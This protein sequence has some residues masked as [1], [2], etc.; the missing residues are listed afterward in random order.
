MM[1]D[2]SLSQWSS[3]LPYK[4]ASVHAAYVSLIENAQHFIYIENQYFISAENQVAVTLR[5][6]IARAISNK[7]VFRAY[8]CVPITPCGQWESTSIKYV[9]KWQY[10][11]INKDI[12]NP[13]RE[14]FPGVSINDYVS[15]YSF[16]TAARLGNQVVSDQ[17]YIHSKLMIVDDRVAVIGSANINDRSLCGDRD[18]EIVAIVEDEE[19]VESQ[20]NGNFYLASRFAHSLRV[21]LFS[22]HLGLL[23]DDGTIE[24]R[25]ELLNQINDPICEDTFKFWVATALSNKRIFDTLC[26]DAPRDGIDSFALLRQIREMEPAPFEKRLELL[27]KLRGHLITYPLLFLQNDTFEERGVVVENIVP[28]YVFQ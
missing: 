13:L 25:S 19:Y 3:G 15:F 26:P 20:M 7:E 28:D 27:S 10:K 8:I 5:E 4:E 16:R 12:L 24:N 9:M 22:E 23:S 14:R 17:V 18:S 11:T 2:R 21:S 6:R 1:E